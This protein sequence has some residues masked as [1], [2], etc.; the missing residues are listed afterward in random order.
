MGYRQVSYKNVAVSLVLPL[1]WLCLAPAL[2]GSLAP[3]LIGSQ[4]PGG[5][6][7][8]WHLTPPP[9]V[10]F[11]SRH[12][13]SVSCRVWPGHF[14]WV[15]YLVFAFNLH[16]GHFAGLLGLCPS[17]QVWLTPSFLHG[18][19]DVQAGAAWLPPPCCLWCPFQPVLW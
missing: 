9:K 16:R 13:P 7:W 12:L 4:R 5:Q 1:L 18:P 17:S 6:R 8:T 19:P 2:I 15:W 11:F 10:S 14:P 3:G